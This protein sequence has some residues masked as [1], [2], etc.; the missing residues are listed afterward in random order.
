MV[1][2]DANVENNDMREFLYRD[3]TNL[4][5]YCKAMYGLAL[6]KQ[7]HKDKLDM[8]LPHASMVH[9]KTYFGGGLWYTLDLDYPRLVALLRKHNYKGYISLEFEGKENPR[10]GV[11]KSLDV[12]RKAFMA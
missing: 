11:P 7:N 4:A 3:R 5:V 1:L 9:M 12:I 8:I 2:A 6:H 10:T